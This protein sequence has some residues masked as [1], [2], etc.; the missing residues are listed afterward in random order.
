MLFKEGCKAKICQFDVR[1]L[2]RYALLRD[3]QNVLWLDV[4]MGNVLLVHVV[5]CQK[6]LL[7][8]VGCLSL[9]HPLDLDHVLVELSSRHQLRDDVEV[10]LVLQKLHGPHDVGV[11]RVLDDLELLLHQLDEHLVLAYHCLVDNFHGALL[12]GDLVQHKP[13]LS[14]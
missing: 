13:H 4:S 1:I 8:N 2:G 14:E 12:V 10:Y 5:E 9:A 7:Y 6:D 11:V 3:D